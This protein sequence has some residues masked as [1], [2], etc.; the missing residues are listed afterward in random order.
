MRVLIADDV[1]FIRDML[2]ELLIDA[3]FEVV[4]MAV[5]G[6]DALEKYR[7][8]KPDVILMDIMM[9]PGVGGLEA[10]RSII[11]MDPAAFIIMVSAMGQEAMV[12]EA[13]AAGARDFITKPFLPEEII[14][15]LEKV[16]A[17]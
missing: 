14:E 5:D 10:L 6:A 16:H 3:G 13:L 11:E 4:G 1:A 8:L 2:Y 7:Q 15:T 12:K 9:R 17:G